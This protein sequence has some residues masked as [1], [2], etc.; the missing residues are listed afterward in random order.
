MCFPLPRKPTKIDKGKYASTLKYKC[1]SESALNEKFFF[2]EHVFIT[3][4]LVKIG[5]K[6]KIYNLCLL[7]PISTISLGIEI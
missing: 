6:H 3:K 2:R 7:C 4:L 1:L 5:R